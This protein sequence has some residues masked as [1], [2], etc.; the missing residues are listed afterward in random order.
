MRNPIYHTNAIS[1]FSEIQFFQILEIS[2]HH[3]LQDN[4][5]QEP[6]SSK[7]IRHLEGIGL[8]G[9]M[10]P[11]DSTGIARK[12]RTANQSWIIYWTSIRI[13]P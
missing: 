8:T 4:R 3:F 2:L 13:Q 10:P 5:K 12:K 1:A 7:E 9:E 11:P 6:V